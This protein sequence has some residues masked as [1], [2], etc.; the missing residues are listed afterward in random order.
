MRSAATQSLFTKR[1]AR[2]PED[3]V[4][5]HLFSPHTWEIQDM[6]WDLRDKKNERRVDV[7]DEIL[8]R[9]IVHEN[10]SESG[11]A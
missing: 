5:A 2:E 11:V 4:L 10:N 9:C 1:G 8:R 6:S 3:T 7:K